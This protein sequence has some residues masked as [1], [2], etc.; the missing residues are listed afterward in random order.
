MVVLF[1][2]K[3]MNDKLLFIN[4]VNQRFGSSLEQWKT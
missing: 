2:D 1:V 3:F 4:C